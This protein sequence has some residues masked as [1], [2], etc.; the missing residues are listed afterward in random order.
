MCSVF[1]GFTSL[2]TFTAVVLLT[3]NSV[4]TLEC[5]AGMASHTPGLP[6]SCGIHLYMW[7]ATP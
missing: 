2:S 1:W 4:A 7:N 5:D 6:C 3:F